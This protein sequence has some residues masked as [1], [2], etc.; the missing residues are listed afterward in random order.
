VKFSK[1]DQ[2]DYARSAA[3]LLIY[4][5]V[6]GGSAFR[7]LPDQWY[8]W[9]LLVLAGL[10]LLVSWHR[11]QMVYQCPKCGHVYKLSF[12]VDLVAPHGVDK[13]GAWLLLRCP[14]CRQRSKT[15]VLK[16]VE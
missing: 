12:W 16:R 11:G 14:A 5:L 3:Y 15:R 6:I 4:L 8:L 2:S 9:G 13:D 7:L 10:A 1:P